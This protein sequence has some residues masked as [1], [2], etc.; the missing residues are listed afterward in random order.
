[1]KSRNS[2]TEPGQPWVMMSGIG[3]GPLPFSWMKW[4]SMPSTGAVKL[5]KPLITASC[6][7]QSYSSTQ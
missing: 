1:M 5:S 6:L 2:V 7:R 3:F 4:I